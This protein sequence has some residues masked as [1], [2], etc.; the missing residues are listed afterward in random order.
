MA[1]GGVDVNECIVN[2]CS[3]YPLSSGEW[4]LGGMN[5]SV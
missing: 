2:S 1:N 3:C 5:G 4:S